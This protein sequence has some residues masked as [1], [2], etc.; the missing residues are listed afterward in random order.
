MIVL[1]RKG[2]RGRIDLLLF[3]PDCQSLFASSNNGASLWSGLPNA[4]PRHVFPNYRY[5]RRARF[6]PDSRYLITDYNALTIHDLS[7]GTERHFELWSHYLSYFDLAPDGRLLL[8]AQINRDPPSGWIACCSVDNPTP[9]D[10]VWSGELSRSLRISPT[11]VAGNR[12]VLMESWWEQSLMR[13]VFR[14]VTRS[15]KTG[16]ELVSVEG[17]EIGDFPPV[18]TPDG[19]FLAGLQNAC[20]IVLSVED[21]SKSAATLRNDNRKYFTNIAFHPSGRYLGATSND[22]TVKLFDTT[23]WEV[24]RTFTWDIGRMRSIA[25]SPDGVLAAAGSDTGKVVVWDVDI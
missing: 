19:R 3:A 10:A 17:P 7:D 16:E 4:V 14:Y 18:V 20:V 5:I 25:F 2:E 15:L 12:F 13:G 11:C 23:T 21:F 6:I 24:A 1:H 22:A 8:I 9:R